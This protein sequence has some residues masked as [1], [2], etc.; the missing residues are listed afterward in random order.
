LQP[1]A[2]ACAERQAEGTWISS[3]WLARGYQ[4]TGQLKRAQALFE[5]IYATANRVDG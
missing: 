1:R 5:R 4:F 2:N 3:V